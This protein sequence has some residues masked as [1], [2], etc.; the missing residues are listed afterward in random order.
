MG[1]VARGVRAPRPAVRGARKTAGVPRVLVLA[2][3]T[4][5]GVALGHGGE[6]FWLCVPAALLAGAA[7][8][9]QIGAALAGA[10]VVAAAGAPALAAGGTRH[11]PVALALLIP[12]ASLAILIA[13]RGRLRR[14]LDSLRATALRDPLTG[15]ANRR[16]LLERVDYEIVRHTR[17]GRGFCVLMLDLDGFKAL[18]DRFG[19]AAGDDLLREVAGALGRA[20]RD[21]DTVARLGGDEFCVLAPETDAAGAQRLLA[22]AMAAV[23]RVTTGLE[24]LA[25]SAGA[26]VFPED[27]TTIEPLLEAADRR[28]L[29]VKRRRQRARPERRAA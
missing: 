21:Q 11:P 18:N 6:A 28:L 4:A 3:L 19:H 2:I 24:T 23:G 26:A 27:G 9:K 12:A 10:L 20:V 25:A 16:S 15:L 29:E 7:V 5:A 1:P 14:E 13:V 8:P 22:R 17:S